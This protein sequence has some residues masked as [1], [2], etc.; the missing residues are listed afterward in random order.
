MNGIEYKVLREAMCL[1]QKSLAELLEVSRETVT[2]REALQEKKVPEEAALAISYLV[3]QR[4]PD[5]P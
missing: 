1:T 5:E 2:R 4:I 3:H